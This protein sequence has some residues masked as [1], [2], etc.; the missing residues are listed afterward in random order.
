[1]L[2][3][4]PFELWTATN[5]PCECA[6]NIVAAG[7][8]PDGDKAVNAF[9]YGT[10]TNPKDFNTNAWPVFDFVTTNGQ[11]YGALTFARAKAATDAA[12]EVFATGILGSDNWQL[13]TNTHAVVDQTTTERV[14]LRDALPATSA[15]R[16]YELRIRLKQE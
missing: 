8:D 9:E 16:F 13:L 2:P 5:W 12:C 6:T 10:G 1:V 14:T 3:L 7:A 15:A 4:R 11:A